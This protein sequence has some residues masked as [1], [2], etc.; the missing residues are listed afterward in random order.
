MSP[1]WNGEI[2]EL[3]SEF[4]NDDLNAEGGYEKVLLKIIK[5]IDSSENP[6][7]TGGQFAFMEDS[8]LGFE[9]WSIAIETIDFLKERGARFDR[10]KA[11]D[12]VLEFGKEYV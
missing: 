3:Y 7:R 2:A 11:L 6:E 10:R 9:S 5:Y 1:I 4:H 12:Y 8:N